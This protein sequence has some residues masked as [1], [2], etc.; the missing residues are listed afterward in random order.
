MSLVKFIDI[1]DQ[2]L[3]N[4]DGSQISIV[5]KEKA[6][7]KAVLEIDAPKSISITVVSKNKVWVGTPS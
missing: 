4:V 6:G 1:D 7:R 2:L 3:F 5:L